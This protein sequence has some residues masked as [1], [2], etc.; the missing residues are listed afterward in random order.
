MVWSLQLFRQGGWARISQAFTELPQSTEQILHAE[1]Y[2]AREAPM[3]VHTPDISSVLGARWKRIDY[4]INGE[5]G[6]YLILD[7]YL[8]A[9]DESKRAAAGW[10][11]DRY[12][13]Y[14]EARS[15][16]LFLTQLTRWDT[17]QDAREFYDAYAKRTAQRY[18]GANAA[19][20]QLNS[21]N[22]RARQSSKGIVQMKLRRA[23]VLVDEGVVEKAKGKK[24]MKASMQ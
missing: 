10:G 14:E 8:K 20:I 17:E 12:A 1:K 24:V 22:E 5:W 19:E 3:R 21:A 16:K 7:E 4:D 15:G 6:L 9:V 18:K 13:L 23:Q 2:L 11:G